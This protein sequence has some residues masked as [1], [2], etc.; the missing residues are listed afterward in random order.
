MEEVTSRKLR[1]ISGW[2]IFQRENLRQK[3]SL[4][5]EQ[6]K[7]EVALVASKWKS[8]SPADRLAFETQAEFETQKR[9]E[10][11]D[12]P[13]TPALSARPAVEADVGSAGLKH[14]SASRLQ[15]N[16][17]DER[18]HPLWADLCQLGESTSSNM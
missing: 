8:L 2:N 10:A 6:Y 7:S 5:P 14:I 4:A 17:N 18:S 12:T 13:L 1:K 15:C 16:F 3:G 9:L 11:K